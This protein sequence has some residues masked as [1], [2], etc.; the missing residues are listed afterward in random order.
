MSDHFPLSWAEWKEG[1][2]N[3]YQLKEIL[4]ERLEAGIALSREEDSILRA[5]RRVAA[6]YERNGRKK[7][8]TRPESSPR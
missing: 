7:L 3:L 1:T 5:A 2:E 6:R 4:E 8:P